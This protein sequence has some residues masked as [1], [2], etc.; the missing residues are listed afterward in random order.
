[1]VTVKKYKLLG[2]H[3]EIGETKEDLHQVGI[4][5]PARSAFNRP[6][7]P[8]KK[9]VGSWRMTMDYQELNKVAVPSTTTVLDP[10]AT[11]LEMYPAVLDLANA[12]FNM[13]LATE[14]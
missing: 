4:V 8:I 6:V 10:S 7:W 3:K 13:F 1:M 11:V 14:P 9:P 2:G 12:L 5:L